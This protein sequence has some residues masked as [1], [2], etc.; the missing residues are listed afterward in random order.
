MEQKSTVHKTILLLDNDEA[1][2]ES[3]K[4]VVEYLAGYSV[5]TAQSMNEVLAHGEKA[6]SC[7]VA[8]LDINL[9]A[10]QPS[11]IDVYHWLRSHGFTKKIIFLT[12]HARTHPIVEAALHFGDV[13]VCSKPIDIDQ[14]VEIIQGDSS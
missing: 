7:D 4:M 2:L 3:L 12:G 1:L 8:V 10:D 6:L 13:K 9:G 5:L 11:G 14:F